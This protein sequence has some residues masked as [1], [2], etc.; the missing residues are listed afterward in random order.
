MATTWYFRDTN[1]A[2]GPTAKQSIRIDNFP[3]VPSDKNTPK[4]MTAASGSG[5]V[6]LA[7]IYNTPNVQYAMQRIF[8]SP[9]LAAQTLTGNQAGYKVAVAFRESA[10]AMNLLFHSL[11]YIWRSGVGAVKTLN[12]YNT[13]A[14]MG[15]D[16]E[17]GAGEYE[18]VYT[19]T[20]QAADFDILQGDRIVVECWFIINNSKETDY[21]ASLYYDGTDTTM[22]D[23]TTTTDAGSYFYCPQTLNLYT[24]PS[25]AIKTINGLA[26]ASVKTVNALAI[27]SVKTWNGLAFWGRDWMGRLFGRAQIEGEHG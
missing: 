12:P 20:G 6:T 13:Y 4:D 17:H 5:Q 25:S 1:A 21:T 24:P 3:L 14:T 8:V 26:I 16:T 10:T 11:P 23:D 19:F 2:A 7:N 27:A 22:V 15:D 9:P 18:C